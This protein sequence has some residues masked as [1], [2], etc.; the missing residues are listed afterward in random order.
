MKL[1]ILLI[2]MLLVIM[3][4]SIATKVEGKVYDFSLNNIKNIIVEVNSHP[5]QRY[6][7]IDGFYSFELNN[8]NYTLSV[9]S[10]N[11]E[12]LGSENIIITQEGNYNIDIILFPNIDEE[13]ETSNLS[14]LSPLES[15]EQQNSNLTII[16]SII[17]IVILGYLFI[18]YKNKISNI[19]KE[20]INNDPL[21]EKV[22]EIIKKETR[23]NQKD[24]RKHFPLSE[25]K[26]SLVISELESK[27]RI[28]KIRKGRANILIFKK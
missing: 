19:N 13:I 1:Y 21:L 8:G 16:I 9:F 20:I 24:L 4:L 11:N 2:V 18:Y 28:E 6:L 17:L 3:P 12:L 25:S 10:R 26:I 7:S 5:Q 22:F 23:I 14:E 15:V 27:G